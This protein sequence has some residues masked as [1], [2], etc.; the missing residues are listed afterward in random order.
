[1]SNPVTLG[2]VR[3]GLR[4]AIIGVVV[5]LLVAR[6]SDRREREVVTVVATSPSSSAIPV[7]DDGI[8][9]APPKTGGIAIVDP[10]VSAVR[11]VAEGLK[12]PR[13]IVVEP[14]GDLL[15]VTIGGQ[16]I[17]HL[18]DPSSNPTLQTPRILLDA[19]PF[20]LTHALIRHG[21]YIYASSA[22]VV[23]RFPHASGSDAPIDP[24]TAEVVVRD[25]NG[26]DGMYG[27]ATRSLL[28]SGG[29]LHVSI[30]SRANVDRDSR[31]ARVRRFPLTF[32]SGGHVFE[33]GEVL[34]DGT[35]NCVALAT[36]SLGRVWGAENGADNLSRRDLATQDRDYHDDS[37]VEEVNLFDGDAPGAFYGYPY[38]FT[39]GNTTGTFREDKGR[40]TQFGWPGFEDSHGD[41]WCRE[42]KNNRPPAAH[43]PAHSAPISMEFLKEG[44]A[45]GGDGGVP[46]EANGSLFV[47]L[48]GSW[49]R[50]IP[51]GYALVMLS[52]STQNPTGVIRRLIE[53]E[54]HASMCIGRLSE[55]CF[56][57]TGMAFSPQ[58]KVYVASDATGVV[59]EVTFA[60]WREDATQEEDEEELDE[61][62]ERL[63][64]VKQE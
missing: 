28:V 38:C 13:S 61:H 1:M 35:R 44:M 63:E 46:C 11:V 19:A 6:F 31:Y 15:I 47:T 49:N 24:D 45:C 26:A 27:H 7:T 37:P 5:L 60:G 54:D 52:F 40:G 51:S 42:L 4:I 55:K 16:E 20:K 57:P 50:D 25:I 59:V 56:R 12:Y 8:S 33:D 30:G 53:A 29:Y 39:A 18:K 22:D 32:P 9:Q 48:R 10:I 14:N 3:T 58:G 21:E 34:A 36:D 2:P 43:I 17:L 41:A 64:L 23:Y 62:E